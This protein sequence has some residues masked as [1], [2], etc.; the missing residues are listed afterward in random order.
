M[1]KNYKFGNH[2]ALH[3]KSRTD[4]VTRKLRNAMIEIEKDIE[5]NEGLYPFNGGRL[6]LAEVC[7][8]AGVH[9]ITLQGDVHKE[10]T[11]VVV[12]EWLASLDKKLFGGS[13]TVRKRVNESADEWRVRYF[14]LARKY[15][16]LYAIEILSRDTKIKAALTKIIEL[17]AEVSKL[18]EQL[19]STK[20]VVLRGAGEG[21]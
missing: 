19:A 9:K 17:E 15:N 10:T 8:R 18:Q 6:S 21:N 2:L 5:L 3:A 4:E 7:R 16:E 14:D 13:K 12:K 20:V 1:A 11:K